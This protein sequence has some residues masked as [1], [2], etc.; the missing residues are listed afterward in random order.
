MSPE[1]YKNI[2]VNVLLAVATL[3]LAAFTGSRAG[4]FAAGK[5]TARVT[6]TEIA[7]MRHSSSIAKGA[8]DHLQL[9]VEQ[10]KEVSILKTD[11]KYIRSSMDGMKASQRAFHVDIMDEIRALRK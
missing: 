10:A 5:L 1:A 7:L 2:G 6:G 4:G 9:R 8:E 11:V 3:A